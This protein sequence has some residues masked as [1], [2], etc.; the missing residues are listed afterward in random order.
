MKKVAPLVDYLWLKFGKKRESTVK[1]KFEIFG[2]C[3]ETY[4]IFVSLARETSRSG[5]TL[6]TRKFFK[7][8][9]KRKLFSCDLKFFE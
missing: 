1:R 7:K 9:K 2:S 8:S 6:V 5:S 3:Y 4:S